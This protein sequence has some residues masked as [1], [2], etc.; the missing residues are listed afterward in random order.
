M[1]RTPYIIHKV[2]IFISTIT[3]LVKNRDF[4]SSL[5]L[6]DRSKKYLLFDTNTFFSRIYRKLGMAPILVG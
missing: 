6:K 4:Y 1:L 5:H 3:Q 2:L